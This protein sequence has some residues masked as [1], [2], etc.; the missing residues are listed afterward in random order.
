[1]ADK[2]A[3]TDRFLAR[4]P[5]CPVVKELSERGFLRV[6]L[7]KWVELSCPDCG[8]RAYYV[9]P[10]ECTP[11]VGVYACTCGMTTASLLA[12]LKISEFDADWR[13][14]LVLQDGEFR[15]AVLTI[16]KRLAETGR[17]FRFCGQLVE[18][19]DRGRDV[20]M[21]FFTKDSLPMVVASCLSLYRMDR[22]MAG[23]LK[24]RPTDLPDRYGRALL[25]NLGE[26]ELP[27]L[28]G[29]VECPLLMPDGRL[30]VGR[31]YDPDS[32]FWLNLNPQAF[33]GTVERVSR[34]DAQKAYGR[35]QKVLAGFSFAR[36]S[37]E[38]AAVAS[39]LCAVLKPSVQRCPL[40]HIFASSPGA[41]KSSLTKALSLLP[42]RTGSAT[43]LSFPSSEEEMQR[44]LSSVLRKA[45]KVVIF[46]NLKS[47]LVPYGALCT[48]LTEGHFSARG[49]GSNSLID[50]GNEAIFITNGN[51]VLP[52]QDMVR[53]TLL[54]QLS[55]QPFRAVDRSQ[56]IED[57]FT[58]QRI[59]IMT[60]A[61]IIVRAWITSGKSTFDAFP[62]FPE[63][64]SKCRFPLLWLGKPDP[65][66]RT[67]ELLKKGDTEDGLCEVIEILKRRFQ[68]ATFRVAD[69]DGWFKKVSG[70][71]ES[72]K[73]L[74][75]IF[76][77]WGL[78]NGEKV[79]A[80]KVGRKL[81]RM[82]ETARVGSCLEIVERKSPVSF[83]VVYRS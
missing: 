28:R 18:I 42:T 29:V 37:D 53:R 61:L 39:I 32:R 40:I 31:G 81:V 51:G 59:A 13:D 46:D 71:D 5:E 30:K 50:V 83:R 23:E 7:G 12:L 76:E 33:E 54:I 79:N 80:R 66:Q 67:F 15:Y 72:Q 64:D 77:E 22:R 45:P 14:K 4:E 52:R 35:L 25:S 49:L 82:A 3:R 43:Y 62:S 2:I 68:K 20:E 6:R 16:E 65:L 60:D 8:A 58:R 1:M 17:I 75:S 21:L 69:I 11:L 10:S 41:G 63:W 73:R 36:E 27:A 26:S 74:K 48:S 78:M 55:N 70:D 34:E 47:D 44:L 57:L 24:L 38:V 56:T 19:F 9:L